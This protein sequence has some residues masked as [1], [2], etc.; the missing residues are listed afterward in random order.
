MTT[1]ANFTLI[2]L[3]LLLLAGC[4]GPTPAA[5]PGEVE[6]GPEGH[7]ISIEGIRVTAGE[8]L[9]IRGTTTLPED[10]CVY[11]QLYANDAEVDWWLVGKCYPPEGPNWEF[12]IPLG[13]E[14]TPAELDP[15]IAYRLEVWWPGAPGE[16]RDVFEFD[17][18]GPPAP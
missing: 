15:D 6:E 2:A 5:G 3:I 8:G 9:T 17:L 4:T 7:T 11:T 1:R 12:N 10:H 18:A 16:T 13:A 14:G